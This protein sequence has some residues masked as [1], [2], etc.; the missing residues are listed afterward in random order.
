[1]RMTQLYLSGNIDYHERADRRQLFYRACCLLWKNRISGD[2]VEFGC[3]GGMTFVLAYHHFEQFHRPDFPR[4]LWAFDSF[5]GLPAQADPKDAH[6]SW[7]EGWLKTSQE[8]FVDICSRSG[9]PRSA[10]QIVP[11]FYKDTIGRNATN[12]PAQLPQEI[13]FAC[14]DCDLYASTKSVLEF[15]GSRL[16]HGMIIALDDYYCC[17]EEAAAGERVALLELLRNQD[18]FLLVP[19]VQYGYAGMSFI[20]EDRRFNAP[21]RALLMSH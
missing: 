21:D 18:R 20:L 5:Q 3:H 6:P 16:K 17:S 14:I 11:G 4:K 7:Q 15:L 1:M 12:P 2:Y 13:A 8:E 10:Y 9:V 19:Y